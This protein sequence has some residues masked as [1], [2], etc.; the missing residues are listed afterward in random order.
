MKS[1]LYF[2]FYFAQ[3]NLAKA[4]MHKILIKRMNLYVVYFAGCTFRVYS[5]SP[6][7]PYSLFLRNHQAVEVPA[8]HVQFS[9]LYRSLQNVKQDYTRLLPYKQEWYIK[10]E[11]TLDRCF[12]IFCKEINFLASCLLF[13]TSNSLWKRVRSLGSKILYCQGR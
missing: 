7:L 13:C 9:N 2:R 3:I 5:R 11:D 10:G 6:I 12:T 4:M 8:L 1:A